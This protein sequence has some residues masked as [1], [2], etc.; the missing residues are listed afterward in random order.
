MLEASYIYDGFSDYW[1][2]C[3]DRYDNNKGCLFAF[4]GSKTTLRD[5]ID[6][7]VDDYFNG[8]DC[9]TMPKHITSEMVRAA[10]LDMLTD[11]G[12]ADYDSGA[13][14]ECAFGLE[15]RDDAD[16]DWESPIAV[17][18]LEYSEDED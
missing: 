12:R 13:I 2:G 1:S 14:A 7:W 17:V 6:E 3:G 4:Y 8:G 16:D 10:L 5:L 11:S 18:L 15:D 9:D